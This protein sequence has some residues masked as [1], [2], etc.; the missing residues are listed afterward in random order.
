MVSPI[1]V[2]DLSIDVRAGERW[3]VGVLGEDVPM[4]VAEGCKCRQR[5]ERAHKRV[6]VK[7]VRLFRSSHVLMMKISLRTNGLVL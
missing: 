5:T 1:F 2:F 6:N 7:S 3:R 4:R